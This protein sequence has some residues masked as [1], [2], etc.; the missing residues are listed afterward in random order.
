MHVC[1]VR[2][3]LEIPSSHSQ[4]NKRQ[5]MRKLLDRLHARL[6]LSIAEV[7]ELDTWHRASLGFAEVGSSAAQVH[8]QA[9][10]VLNLIEETYLAHIVEREMETLSFN[11]DFFGTPLG[12]SPLT[13]ARTDRSLAEREGMGSWEGRYGVGVAA[14]VSAKALLPEDARARAR[15]MRRRRDWEK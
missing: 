11:E 13:V 15:Q 2:V 8:A 12:D 6:D 1:I 14:K 5:V 7:G 10:K 4:K 3:L 9:Q